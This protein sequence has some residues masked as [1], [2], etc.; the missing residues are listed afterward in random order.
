MAYPHFV[1]EETKAN[2]DRLH[3]CSVTKLGLEF[4]SAQLLARPLPITPG[5]RGKDADF[6]FYLS[7][8]QTLS[9]PQNGSDRIRVTPNHKIK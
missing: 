2:R 8:A 3:N 4:G 9:K 6:Q 5:K 1:E 7:D